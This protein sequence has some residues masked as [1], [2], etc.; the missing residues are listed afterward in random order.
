M[1]LAVVGWWQLAT[2]RAH[3]NGTKKIE[4]YKINTINSTENENATQT[5]QSSNKKIQ[6][7]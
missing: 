4:T 7:P 2:C 6:R 3:K 5:I 1:Q